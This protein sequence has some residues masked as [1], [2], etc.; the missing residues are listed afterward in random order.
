[1][2]RLRLAFFAAVLASSL[3]ISAG[4]ETSTMGDAQ[5]FAA[6]REIMV[7]GFRA[8][9]IG[10]EYRHGFVGLHAGA[11]T[12]VLDT[13][14]RATWFFKAGATAYFLP[15]RLTSER[16]SSLYV[17]ASWLHGTGAEWGNAFMPEAGFRWA[18]WKGIDLRLGA[19]VLLSPGKRVYVNPTPGISWSISL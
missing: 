17:S 10:V 12:S 19:A 7:H 15:V 6:G 4:A 14:G 1:M 2:P 8:P 18:V 13:A 9:S 11:Y 3:S 5:P 16:F